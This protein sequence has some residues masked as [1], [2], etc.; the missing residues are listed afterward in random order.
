MKWTDKRYPEEPKQ[1]LNPQIELLCWIF[2]RLL[3]VGVG[4]ALGLGIVWLLE[5]LRVWPFR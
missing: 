3:L 5:A 4:I 2:V 1:E